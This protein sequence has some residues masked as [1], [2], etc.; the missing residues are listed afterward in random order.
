MYSETRDKIAGV[1]ERRG[2][3]RRVLVH[4]GVASVAES[5]SPVSSSPGREDRPLFET[6]SARMLEEACSL[7][8]L[9]SVQS[10]SRGKP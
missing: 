5:S 4:R 7:S 9:R 6:P 2:Q 3:N 8:S 1:E 10:H